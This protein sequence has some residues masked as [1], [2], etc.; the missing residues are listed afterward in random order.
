MP[1]VQRPSGLELD[2]PA[3]FTLQQGAT[4]S[5]PSRR[6]PVGRRFGPVPMSTP[7]PAATDSPWQQAL[8]AAFENEEMTQVDQW[9]VEPR[10]GTQTRSRAAGTPE[11]QVAVP[12]D[13]RED[14]AILLEQDGFFSW[15]FPTEV[16][17]APAAAGRRGPL[18]VGPARQARFRLSLVAGEQAGSGPA[19]PRGVVGDFLLGRV[20]AYVFKFAARI[21]VGQ[22]MKFLE[23][24]VQRGLVY[25]PGPDP[26]TWQLT[27][28]ATLP[29]PADRPARVLLLVHG[30]FSSTISAYGA[31]VATPWGQAFLAAA[32]AT[33]DL[34]IGF[35]H[36]TLSEDP[37]ANASELLQALQAVPWPVPPRLDAVCHS[38]GGLVLR[39]LLEELLPLTA[40]AP[41]VER[42]VFV[43][44]TNG[45]TLLAEPA[46]WQAMVDL[47][48]NLAVTTCQLLGQL[49]QA[50]ALTTV[51]AEIVRSLGAFVKYLA[52]TA[53]TDRGVPGLAAMEPDGEFI[54][55]LNQQQ[56]GQ[57]TI[58]QSNYYAVTS[59]FR[60]QV[61]GGEHEPRELPARLVQ[62][63]AGGFMQALMREPNDLVVHTAAMTQI[64]PAAGNYLKDVL[65]FGENPQVYH[66]NYFVWPRVLNALARW[67][68]LTQPVSLSAAPA[69][70]TRRATPRHA[71]R[72]GVPAS[73]ETGP[74]RFVTAELPVAVDL[75]ILVL[76]A[77]L[78]V[79]DALAQVRTIH[80]SF[81]VVQQVELTATQEYVF[82]AEE[83]L[84]LARRAGAT[85]LAEALRLAALSPSATYTG[86]NV[87]TAPPAANP[88]ASTAATHA[89]IRQQGRPVG[90][91]PPA[92]PLL[93]STELIALARRVNQPQR[94]ADF[95]SQRRALPTLQS[96]GGDSFLPLPPLPPLLR[97][98][99]VMAGL[100]GA[101]AHGGFEA[102]TFGDLLPK[103]KSR[104]GR[105][106]GVTE[107]TKPTT[108]TQPVSPRPRR[109]KPQQTTPA[110]VSCYFRAEMDQVVGVGRP[111]T[112]EV[113]LAREALPAASSPAAA[114][115]AAEV[116]PDQVL[117]VQ[118]VPRV[119][120]A[121]VEAAERYRL[122]V[123]VPA[124]GA[125][126]SLFFT[127]RATHAG[128]G[129]VWVQ[130][131]QQQV[132]LLTLSLQPSVAD[133]P[134][135]PAARVQVSAAATAL[136]PAPAV[137]QLTILERRN[138]AELT[139]QFLLQLPALG[140]LTRVESEPFTG[141]RQQYVESIYVEIEQRWLS[142]QTDSDNFTQELRAL[143]GALFDQ[144][145]PPK[146]QALL[147]QYRAQLTS[148]LV[149]SEEPFIP[150]ELVHLHEPDQPLP[151]DEEYFLGQ[152]GLVRWLYAAG[153]PPQSL[154]L[155]PGQAGRAHGAG[156]A[157][158]AAT[159][160]RTGLSA[161]R[162]P[163]G[164]AA[165]QYRQCPTTD[166]GPRGRG[167][168]PAGIPQCQHRRAVRQP[169]AK[170]PPGGAQRLPGRAGG[171]PADRNWRLRPGLPDPGSQCVR[172]HAM[173][174]GR[175][176]GP[177]VYRS[178]LPA[179]AGGRYVG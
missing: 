123:P 116:S 34:V 106:P 111:T 44:V 7:T 25:L 156:C 41:Q 75:D 79:S 98:G 134:A 33:Y 145:I 2:L 11:L 138:G 175:P 36:A 178:I 162:R 22:A 57:P 142:S 37:L 120:F 147:W 84:A 161:L 64:D 169:A 101:T 160:G 108:T 163:R 72:V 96:R 166:A 135:G 112:V 74:G 117:V 18:T 8:V 49:P 155:R 109:A 20:R 26:T 77:S 170:P 100:S 45:G 12:L 179:I 46:N 51:L 110:Q 19:A 144:L 174:G 90:V 32:F 17:V 137:H 89:V 42:V 16:T 70:A 152:L 50:K 54:T 91:L 158:A 61:V 39:C 146:L 132:P 21:I 73:A 167:E 119:N 78:A 87:P 165:R 58:A 82:K 148:I 177:Y 15:Q 128:E 59:E 143:G 93:T 172:G 136:P 68:R 14:A 76:P 127:L 6:A 171:L 153:W 65:A 85:P 62:W 126:S 157:E 95:I 69:A 140:V 63:L 154:R 114:G 103:R 88:T 139:Y 27:D 149:L 30:T 124:A 122:E 10:A 23:R 121:L 4:P 125:P 113:Q 13:G 38:R 159:A 5:A 67:L 105:G 60:P 107:P 40:F 129:E 164:G 80:P 55:R 31:L 118:V 35:D 66:T 173:G 53:V 86:S 83:V 1:I 48:T 133:A 104:A 131:F 28:P 47:Y 94:E 130:I 176:A 56:P 3:D 141:D 102:F 52:S 92:E 24:K 99:V 43:G 168:L 81:V 150:W 151:G 29:L 115:Q 71:G 9:V 97:R